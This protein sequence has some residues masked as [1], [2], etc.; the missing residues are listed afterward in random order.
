MDYDGDGKTELLF[1]DEVVASGCALEF[2]FVGTTRHEKYFCDE[3][4]WGHVR[5]NSLSNRVSPIDGATKDVSARKYKAIYFDE[6]ADGTISTRVEQTDIVAAPVERMAIDATGDGLTDVVTTFECQI[7]GCAWNEAA[8]Q[9]GGTKKDSSLKANR[10]YINRNIGASSDDN[11]YETIDV[12]KQVTNGLGT[13]NQWSYR[14]LGSDEFDISNGAFYDPDHEYISGDIAAGDQEYFHFSSSMM[15]V[16]EHRVS[17]GIG[18]ALNA[19][20]YRYKGAIYNNQ[21]RGFQGFRTIIVDSPAQINSSGEVTE[22]MRSVTDFHQ[23]FPKSGQIEWVHT[24]PVSDGDET[25]RQAP[26]SKTEMQVVQKN[27]ANEKVYW[28]WPEIQKTWT[29]DLKE[30][31]RQLSLRATGDQLKHSDNYGNFSKSNLYIDTGESKLQTRILKKYTVDVDNWWVNKLENSTVRNRTT[32]SVVNPVYDATLNPAKEIQ[33]TYTYNAARLPIKAVS[34]S[35]HDDSPTQVVETSYN[36]NGLPASVKTYLEDKPNDS[37]TVSTTYSKDGESESEE[38][39]YF[40]FKVTNALGQSTTTHTYPEHGQVKKVIDANKLETHTFYDAFGRIEQVTPP[41]GQPVY[42]RFAAC[43]GGCGK[44]TDE[45]IRYKVTTY[46][47]GTP[48]SSVYKDQFNRV[49]A[50]VTEGFDGYPIY[51]FTQYD[52]LG[53]IT[54]ESIPSFNSVEARGTHYLSFDILGRLLKRKI[55]QPE[56]QSM[57]VTYVYAGHRTDITATDMT[58]METLSMSRTYNAKGQ[59][60][61]TTDALGGVTQYAYDALGNPIVMQ[62]AKGNRITAKYNAFGQK[63]E[64]N[65]PNMGVKTFTYTSFGEVDTETDAKGDKT[66]YDYDSLGRLLKRKVN[67]TLEASFEYDGGCIGGLDKEIREDSGSDNF[68]RAYAYDSKC[69]VNKVTTNIDGSSYQMATQY[70]ANY[71]RVKALT[72]PTGLTVENIYNGAGYLSKSQNA[73]SEYV[74]FETGNLDARGQITEAKKANGILTEKSEYFPETGQMKD[75]STQAS[76]GGDQR[77]KL[78]Y[79]YSGFGNLRLQTVENSRDGRNVT[80]TETYLY[81]KLHRLIKSTQSVD[82]TELLPIEYRYDAVGNITRKDDYGSGY[83]YGDVSRSSDNAG[84][85]AVRS[86]TKNLGGTVNFAYDLNGNLTSGDG[87]TITYNAFNKPLTISRNNITSS[88]KYGAD[89][90]RYKQIKTKSGKTETTIY[91]DKAYEKITANGEVQ[92][93]VYLGDAIITTTQKNSAINHKV[94]FVHR[95]RL[96]SVVTITDQN[97]NVIDNKSYDPFGKPRKGTLDKVDPAE[98]A[99]LSSIAQLEGYIDTVDDLKL[100]TRRGFTDHEHLDDA[101][102]IHM[103]GRVYDYNLGRFLSVDPFI[104]EPGNSQSMNPYSYIMNNPLAGTDPSGYCAVSRLKSVCERTPPNRGGSGEGSSSSVETNNGNRPEV[105]HGDH[106][107]VDEAVKILEK[108]GYKFEWGETNADGTATVVLTPP[109]SGGTQSRPQRLPWYATLGDTRGERQVARNI[110][111]RDYGLISSDEFNDR[112][113]AMAVGTAIGLIPSGIAVL[114]A[115][116]PEVLALMEVGGFLHFASSGDAVP[117]QFSQVKGVR[118]LPAPSSKIDELDDL[119]DWLPFHRRVGNSEI[120]KVMA[121]GEIWGKAMSNFYSGAKPYV[122]AY[123]KELPEGFTGYSFIT[124]VKVDSQGT[125]GLPT[126]SGNRH[127]VSSDED[128]ARLTDFVITKVV[129]DK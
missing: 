113:G 16:A 20:Q 101:E 13:Q 9:H 102:L 57:E 7:E 89:Q 46:Q 110:A 15:V 22:K 14:P 88:F 66:D 76:N 40:V 81:D 108:R 123:K 93:K 37:R 122:K 19:T 79:E 58:S 105:L 116:A 65:D 17:S 99:T 56:G 21:G 121:S 125:P 35:L 64:V 23:K 104:Q 44:L 55:D 68:S 47:A 126:W 50:A 95:D 128:W 92:Q 71:G 18:N 109:T 4:L 111:E 127:G 124:R 30:R 70:D 27:T 67:T 91:I 52:R 84:P 87:K 41:V 53:R 112:A 31:T 2:Y 119:G 85:N 75:I 62:D 61:K 77:H 39:G 11:G 98:P 12:I 45:N 6:N 73:N 129:K 32:A 29:F 36:G 34:D 103:N 5:H 117:Y 51:G 28:V 78:F 63:L 94:G 120:D 100:E 49:K 86:L 118:A 54:F 82:G 69:R 59:L 38:G 115:A 43:D 60:I 83:V 1:A 106:K 24:C 107:L 96:G 25:C 42:S 10:L 80:S 8:E 90:M 33:T 72:Y 97:G 48:Q 74:Y 114:G 26:I 3:A